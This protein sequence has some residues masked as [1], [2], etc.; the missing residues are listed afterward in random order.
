M[1]SRG[2][3]V[4]SAG[5]PSPLISLMR[6]PVPLAL[7]TGTTVYWVGPIN[8]SPIINPVK[9]DFPLVK[10]LPC[11][12]T[13]FL[14]SEEHEKSREVLHHSTRAFHKKKTSW[15][16]QSSSRFKFRRIRGHC[17]GTSP[18]FCRSTGPKKWDL[19]C[20]IRAFLASGTS[21]QLVVCSPH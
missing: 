19:W 18:P 10:S 16:L 15:E 17:T 9:N 14:D 21:Q 2:R 8:G 5:G 12:G 11:H 1:S 6:L 7:S 20:G 13:P 3:A 4:F